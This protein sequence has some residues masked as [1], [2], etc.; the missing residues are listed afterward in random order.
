MSDG[1]K[2]LIDGG[3][4]MRIDFFALIIAQVAM[5]KTLLG[6]SVV[7]AALLIVAP[8]PVWRPEGSMSLLRLG[9]AGSSGEVSPSPAGQRGHTIINVQRFGA[10]GDGVTNDTAAIQAAID[11]APQGSTIYFPAGTYVVSNFQ[12]RN[13][14][15]LSFTGE[16]EKSVIKQKAGAPRIVTFDG[17][18]DIV[19]AKIAFDANGI[20]SFG[21]VAFYA[22]KGVRIENTHF[23]DSQ[24]RALG[25]ND[26]FSY[27]FAHGR[28]LSQDIRI[29]KNRID[30]LQ[31]EVDHAQKVVID[32]NTVSRAVRT[33]G[34]GIFSV[35][36]NAIAEDYLITGN[37]V[38]DPVG[39]GFNVGIDP[40]TNRN[41]IFRRIGIINNKVI[42]TKTVG[43]GIRIGTPDNSK[44]TTGNVFEDLVIQANHITVE[45]T[46]P[47]PPPM[48]FANTSANAG[49]AFSRLTIDRNYI[50]NYA[51]GS[52]GY[53]IDL[54]RMQHSFVVANSIK[55]VT[56]GIAL[57]GDLLSNE[58]R[59]N[60]VEASGIAYDLTGSLGEN[61]MYNNRILG[62]PKTRWQT[63]GL[64]PSD[65]VDVD[66]GAAT[67]R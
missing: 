32:G 19:I 47:A 58:V 12:V 50:Q 7:V 46:A 17:A 39:A 44:M 13:R 66:H 29:V 63:S 55:G 21:G 36:D 10:R 4:F 51:G 22:M 49:I 31:L 1:D 34:I 62:S 53:A 15:G 8:V 59:D 40:P 54:R 52:T 6:T 27:V 35:G 11:A 26:R 64:K 38:I 57:A 23:F 56:N 65:A 37:T 33:A 67:P 9:I 43:Y 60:L 28:S 41:C 45:A 20:D 24:P 61:K 5:K 3:P 48:I 42:R 14:S 18:S 25:R 30:D 16:G 2:V